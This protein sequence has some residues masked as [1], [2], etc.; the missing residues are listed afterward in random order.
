M[1]SGTATLDRT[2]H[3]LSHDT[4]RDIL[5]RLSRKAFPVTELA[6]HYSCSLNGVSKHVRVL[7]RAGLVRR[8][9]EGRVHRLKLQARP[10]KEVLECV[11][12]FRRFWE[13]SFDAL[14]DYLVGES[15]DPS[16]DS[17]PSSPS[18]SRL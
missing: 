15:Q 8:T 6:S 5:R 7:E 14:E 3:A 16:I 4:R 2:F 17:R 11:Q 13:Q 9:R 1:N 12:F 18:R 10:L